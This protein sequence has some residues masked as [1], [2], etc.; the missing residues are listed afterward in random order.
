MTRESMVY[1]SPPI[2]REWIRCCVLCCVKSY[3]PTLSL[4]IFGWG[5][6]QVG[7]KS[8]S[9]LP[10]PNIMDRFGCLLECFFYRPVFLFGFAFSHKRSEYFLSVDILY[11]LDNNT[12]NWNLSSNK[13]IISFKNNRN[14]LYNSFFKY[15]TILILLMT[16]TCSL[17]L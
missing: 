7:N 3:L 10:L 5:K 6:V 13:S 14:L 11:T 17:A 15:K 2:T 9:M 4:F 12:R 16:I 1:Y 8:L